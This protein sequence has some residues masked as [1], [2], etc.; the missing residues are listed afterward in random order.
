VNRWLTS[1]RAT[2]QRAM[3]DV[4]ERHRQPRSSRTRLAVALSTLRPEICA[5]SINAGCQR[6]AYN[7]PAGPL[8]QER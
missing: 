5:A 2:S 4:I 3:V 1:R 6:S 8:E 7:P